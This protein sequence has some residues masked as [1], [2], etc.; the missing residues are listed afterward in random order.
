MFWGTAVIL[1]RR[2]ELMLAHRLA[3]IRIGLAPLRERPQ[4]HTLADRAHAAP[5]RTR[6]GPADG[7]VRGRKGNARELRSYLEEAVVLSEAGILDLPAEPATAPRNSDQSTDTFAP[8]HTMVADAERRHIRS[9]LDRT[10]AATL[11]SSPEFAA[12]AKGN[13]PHHR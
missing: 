10:R 7:L 11:R 4:G 6:A 1:K 13:S 12:E 8:L 5:D 9:A 3:V 2:I